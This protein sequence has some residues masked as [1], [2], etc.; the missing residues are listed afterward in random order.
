MSRQGY[1]SLNLL[2][3]CVVR[4]KN[5]DFFVKKKFATDH[6][7]NR[8]SEEKSYI[9][10]QFLSIYNNSIYSNIYHIKFDE[11]VEILFAVDGLSS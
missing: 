8:H 10:K 11:F 4:K 5:Q 1:E 7:I 2:L 9:V 3:F 6:Q